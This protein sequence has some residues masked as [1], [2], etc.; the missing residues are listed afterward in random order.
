ME[1]ILKEV[2]NAVTQEP[3]FVNVT[4]L[5]RNRIHKLLQKKKLMPAKRTLV[6][7][8]V[9]LGTLIRISKLLVGI[10]VGVF[11]MQSQLESSY[12][13]IE[14]YGDTAA[15]IVALAI[16]NAKER[17]SPALVRF[18]KSNLSTQ[19]LL[20]VMSLV[21]RQMNVTGFMA[22]IISMKGLNMLQKTEMS[23]TTQRS[24]IAPGTP[25]EE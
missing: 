5:P 15:A 20:Y 18:I 21:L 14:R 1:E 2:A 13:V 17:P 8:P 24:I 10:D 4:I 22:T 23:P 7:E 3:V 19:E 16:K 12:K 6:L 9:T 11:D 25:S